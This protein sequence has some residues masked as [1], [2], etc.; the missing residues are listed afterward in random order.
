M[1]PTRGW[2]THGT[3]FHKFAIGDGEP[4][5][6]RPRLL[7]HHHTSACRCSAFIHDAGLLDVGH[8]ERGEVDSLTHVCRE[9]LPTRDHPSPRT[10]RSRWSV[11][12][13]CLA[14]E[15]RKA[16]ALRC[17]EQRVAKASMTPP[18]LDADPS[19]QPS[20]PR[21]VRHVDR[22]SSTIWPRG[23]RTTVVPRPD[24]RSQPPVLVTNCRLKMRSLRGVR[25]PSAVL[26]LACTSP[27]PLLCL[28]SACGLC[29]GIPL[30]RPRRPDWVEESDVLWRRLYHGRSIDGALS[31]PLRRTAGRLP[32]RPGGVRRCGQPG[33][34][35][36]ALYHRFFHHR[37]LARQMMTAVRP[38][39]TYGRRKSQSAYPGRAMRLVVADVASPQPHLIGSHS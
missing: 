3:R 12:T 29:D 19:R 39:S 5:I 32:L 31:Y 25:I 37:R 4:R 15:R 17:T 14:V 27:L 1:P 21:S 7:L 36:F 26:L 34:M 18:I 8:R 13:A 24:Q 33:P 2:A 35:C 38:A 30:P 28:G 11:T 16:C 20:N 22:R 10:T 23:L 9:F 6:P